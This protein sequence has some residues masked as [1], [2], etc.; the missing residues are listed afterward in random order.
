MTGIVVVQKCS[1]LMDGQ[2]IFA[3]TLTS[4]I[5]TFF[6]L[7]LMTHMCCTCELF[8]FPY[9]KVLTAISLV[10]IASRIWFTMRKVRGI[11]RRHTL[12]PVL[13]IIVESGALYSASCIILLTLYLLGSNAQ[14]PALDGVRHAPLLL[15]LS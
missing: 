9:I 11:L 5:P 3:S 4:W 12:L 15:K 13:I 14:Y 8:S 6:L 7:T 10:L 2:D 1:T